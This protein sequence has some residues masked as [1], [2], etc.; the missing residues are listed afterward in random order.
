MVAFWQ[1]S[2]HGSGHRYS[3]GSMQGCREALKS[4]V[5]A[6]Q[7]ARDSTIWEGSSLHPKASP[8]LQGA[9][10]VQDIAGEQRVGLALLGRLGAPRLVHGVALALAVRRVGGVVQVGGEGGVG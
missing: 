7:H 3:Q 8:H 6:S 4:N 9:A 1:Q 5:L 2:A 10:G